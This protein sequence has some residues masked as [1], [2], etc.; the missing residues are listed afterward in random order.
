M[1]IEI[2]FNDYLPTPKVIFNFLG[3]MRHQGFISETIELERI[4]EV[5]E[6][7]RLV[8]TS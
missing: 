5:L 8:K 7:K 3:I 4:S 1:D 2:N 6:L